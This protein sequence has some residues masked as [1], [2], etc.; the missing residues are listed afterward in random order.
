MLFQ[1]PAEWRVTPSLKYNCVL[2]N[3]RELLTSAEFRPIL[4]TYRKYCVFFYLKFGIFS[5]RYPSY[6]LYFYPTPITLILIKSIYGVRFNLTFTFSIAC[7]QLN[8]VAKYKSQILPFISDWLYLMR[9][10]VL[11]RSCVQTMPPTLRG[12]F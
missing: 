7:R 5:H 8:L 1:S 10:G 2:V 12:K 4:G 11:W 9:W 6:L 3:E